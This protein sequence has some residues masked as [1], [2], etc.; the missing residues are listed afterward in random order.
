MEEGGRRQKAEG[1]GRE[2]PHKSPQ[3]AGQPAL[4]PF[5]AGA[6]ADAGEQSVCVCVCDTVRFT[7][8]AV[9]YRRSLCTALGE[10]KRPLLRIQAQCTCFP[11]KNPP[12]S[13][14]ALH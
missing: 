8:Y 9:R 5:S 12:S 7:L 10:R 1:E 4:P 11:Q 6:G 13:S 14:D 3:G 2:Q